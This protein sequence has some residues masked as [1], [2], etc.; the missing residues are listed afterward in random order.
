MPNP[1]FLYSQS[2]IA[3]G[4]DDLEAIVRVFGEENVSDLITDVPSGSVVIPRFRSI[5]FGS[6][7]E[8]EIASLGSSLVNTYREHRTI[9]DL[10]S[11]VHLLDGMTAPAYSLEDIPRL[12][13]GEYFLKGETN[14]IKN[15]WFQSAYAPDK[16]H[17]IGVANSIMNDQYVGHQKLVIR[18]FRKFR[19]LGEAVNGRPIFHERRAFIMDG[20][21]VSDAFYWSSF[22]ELGDTQ[23]LSPETYRGTLVEA[24]SRTSHLARFYV[25]DLAEYEDGSWEVIELNDGP[26]SGLSENDCEALW[27]HVYSLLRENPTQ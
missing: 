15:N 13:E 14:S 6:E 26:M 20:Q 10:F 18:P 16:S 5:P 7:L 21:V 23:M 27:S 22:A 1:F 4:G 17:V 3:T 9:A 11:W 12:P 24:V 25:I 19:V 8:R 2:N